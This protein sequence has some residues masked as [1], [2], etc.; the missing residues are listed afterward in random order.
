MDQN[1]IITLIISVFSLVVSVG[2][3]FYTILYHH[4][5]LIGRI[6][7]TSLGSQFS[8][9]INLSNTGNRALLVS[10]VELIIAERFGSEDPIDNSTIKCSKIPFVIN[11]NEMHLVN[12][13]LEKWF[14]EQGFKEKLLVHIVFT[15]FSLKG[16]CYFLFTDLDFINEKDD[17]FP[18]VSHKQF[19]LS[20]KHIYDCIKKNHRYRYE[21]LRQI[22]SKNRKAPS[23]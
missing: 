1:Q 13:G 2:T 21:I 10:D 6:V 5:S 9:S 22:D 11:P 17:L 7:R 12:I 23:S 4:N 18:D 15:I 8:V 3:F 19:K 20:N 16:A 14:Y